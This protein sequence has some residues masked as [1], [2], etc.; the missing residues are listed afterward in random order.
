MPSRLRATVRR[1]AR[2]TRLPLICLCAVS[3][4]HTAPSEISISLNGLLGF[5][6][7]VK[8]S[9]P[10]S[11]IDIR[12]NIKWTCL[13]KGQN[14]SSRLYV[15]RLLYHWYHVHSFSASPFYSSS[16][17][18]TSDVW[19]LLDLRYQLEHLTTSLESP[20]PPFSFCPETNDS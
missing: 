3:I 12:I 9:P 2:S 17:V 6:L 7:S 14:N 1:R 5:G 16:H 8:K 4:Q 10:D 15:S 13:F 11:A 19:T 20:V 18:P